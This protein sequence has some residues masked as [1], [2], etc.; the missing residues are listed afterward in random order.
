MRNLMRH[1][2]GDPLSRLGQISTEF[3]PNLDYG[4]GCQYSLFEQGVACT[5]WLRATWHE[6]RDKAEQ[7]S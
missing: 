2:A 4:E 6:I 1:H 7:A 3:I 5:E